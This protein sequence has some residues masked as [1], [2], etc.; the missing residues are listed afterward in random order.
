MKPK[1][2]IVLVAL[3]AVIYF[4]FTGKQ[5]E[6]ARNADLPDLAGT[7]GLTYVGEAAPSAIT[8]TAFPVIADVPDLKSGNLMTGTHGSAE[9]RVADISFRLD[10]ANNEIAG[11]E[12]PNR[13]EQTVVVVSDST[14][15]LPD[16]VIRPTSIIELKAT[17]AYETAKEKAGEVVEMVDQKYGT[18]IRRIGDQIEV[19][20]SQI[21]E[22]VGDV[23][24]DVAADVKDK[25]KDLT[26]K[27][28]DLGEKA[29]DRV[30]PQVQG[31]V[32]DLDP[33]VRQLIADLDP[34]VR[35]V[36]SDIANFL[37]QMPTLDIDFPDQPEFSEKYMLVGANPEAI[38]GALSDQTLEYLGR[39][40]PLSVEARGSE[41]I[42]YRSG[43]IA[44]EGEL[45]T[46]VEEAR[47]IHELLNGQ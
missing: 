9:L 1:L 37:P 18:E 10:T 4:I 5:E 7:L 3:A 26:D 19:K 42:V 11:N 30:N 41:F 22:Q 2:I 21:A 44:G 27:A 39:I 24:K 20:Y 35:G 32:A 31:V 25:T 6:A 46:L 29:M 15:D 16:M 45:G 12:N 38:G 28:K 34:K 40:A 14:M 13:R 47:R 33:K 23:A 17:E 8:T 36:L 43:N